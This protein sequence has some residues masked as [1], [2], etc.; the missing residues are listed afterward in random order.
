MSWA[1]NLVAHAFYGLWAILFNPSWDVHVLDHNHVTSIP[2]TYTQSFIP[3]T[4]YRDSWTKKNEPVK[5]E[6]PEPLL[7]KPEKTRSR[8][9]SSQ[10]KK[11]FK[12]EE[13]A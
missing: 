11:V 5:N 8:G 7:P 1:S 10:A 4:A 6:K 2:V 12:L 13:M 3:L 9:H